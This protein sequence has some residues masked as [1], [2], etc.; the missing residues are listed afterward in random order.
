MKE[1]KTVEGAIVEQVHLLM[2]ATSMGVVDFLEGS[3]LSGLTSW[4]RKKT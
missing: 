1:F 3:F 4:A 2:P